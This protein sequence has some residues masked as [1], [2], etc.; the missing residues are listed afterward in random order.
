M[1]ELYAPPWLQEGIGNLGVKEGPGNKDNPV[2][3]KYYADAGFPGI[4]HDD[5]AWCAAFV[6]AMLK[7]RGFIPSG[8]LAARS[9]LAFPQ[10]HKPM[11]GAIG[12]KKRTGGLSYQGHVGIVVAADGEHIFML[13]GNQHD[14]VN[15]SKFPAKE[16]L[17]F[18]VPKGFNPTLLSP[19]P[20][21]VPSNLKSMVVT[22]PVKE[23]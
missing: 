22:G 13:G 4:K 20:K 6:G 21:S 5:V 11:F 23:N 7:R 10:L 14:M 17:G 1:P 9:Y 18:V 12:V 2:V 3:L 16:F 19:A 8:S 15:I